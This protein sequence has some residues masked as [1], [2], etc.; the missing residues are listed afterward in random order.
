MYVTWFEERRNWRP[1][2]EG[3]SLSLPLS[4][5]PSL[6]LSLALSFLPRSLFPLSLFPL[7]LSFLFPTLCAYDIAYAL[8]EN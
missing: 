8:E 6:S 1:C 2:K 3:L 4:L 7:S 5:S